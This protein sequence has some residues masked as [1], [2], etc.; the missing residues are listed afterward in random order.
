MPTLVYQ[1]RLPNCP[2]KSCVGFLV[3]FVPNAATPPHRHAGASVCAFVLEGTLLNKMNDSPTRVVTAG[4]SFFEAPGCH[5]KVSE[6]YSATEGAKLLATM[7]V[8]TE[9]VEKGGAAALVVIDEEY[10]RFLPSG[11]V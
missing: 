9:I 6:T 5:H 8:D 3:N 7:V 2:G 4:E 11:K 1:H 10:R